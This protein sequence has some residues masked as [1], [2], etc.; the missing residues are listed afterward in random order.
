MVG[1]ACSGGQQ[2]LDQTSTTSPFA[3]TAPPIVL[4]TS[5]TSTSVAEAVVFSTSTPDHP[6]FATAI[7][8]RGGI[9]ERFTYACPGGGP[10]AVVWGSD[11]Y[12][13]DSSVCTAAV[14]SGAITLL[15]GGEVVIEI[16]EGQS[17]YRATTANGIT[18]EPWDAW[19]GSFVIIDP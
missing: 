15:E 18:T 14:H 6:W 2:T 13:D 10:A 4:T 17:S 1:Q 16:R 11:I 12:T 5:S 7:E 19:D 9:G 8:H 3:I